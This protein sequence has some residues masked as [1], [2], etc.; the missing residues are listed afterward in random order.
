MFYT[1]SINTKQ[2]EASRLIY[3]SLAVFSYSNPTKMILIDRFS[4][5]PYG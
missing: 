2:P 1:D 3:L 4:I 5:E